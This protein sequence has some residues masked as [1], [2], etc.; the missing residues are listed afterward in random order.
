M[1]LSINDGLTCARTYPPNPEDC[2]SDTVLFVR[3]DVLRFGPYPRE[4]SRQQEKVTSAAE[5]ESAD[6]VG[7]GGHPN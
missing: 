6:T 4:A 1:F 2:V 5:L 7:S 3:R